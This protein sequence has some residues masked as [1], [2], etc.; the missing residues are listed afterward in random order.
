MVQDLRG[1]GAADDAQDRRD[2]LRQELSD[3]LG[4]EVEFA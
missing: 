3:F 1:L 4:G 2:S